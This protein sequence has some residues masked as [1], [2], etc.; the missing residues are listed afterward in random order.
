VTDNATGGSQSTSLTGTGVDFTVSAASSHNTIAAGGTAMYS[1]TV[2]AAGGTFSNAVSFACTGLPAGATCGFSPATV[3]P[4]ATSA[5]VTLTITTAVAGV[6]KRPFSA[7]WM[8]LPGFG[9]LG[10]FFLLSGKR[11]K[12]LTMFAMLGCVLAVTMLMTGCGGS[13]NSG[14]GGGGGT[15]YNV[16]VT[17]SAGTLQHTLPLTLTVQ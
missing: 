7:F 10:M 13:S 9:L 1:L 6:V 5:P 4:G 2:T 15:T 8:Q 11:S 12:R 3:T 17:A 14:G 16:T